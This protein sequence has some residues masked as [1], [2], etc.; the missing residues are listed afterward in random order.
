MSGYRSASLIRCEG[1]EAHHMK[2]IKVSLLIYV[3][4]ALRLSFTLFRVQL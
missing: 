1:F 3:T 4:R 2:N